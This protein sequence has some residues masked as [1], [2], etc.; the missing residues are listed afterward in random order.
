MQIGDIRVD[1]LIDGEVAVPPDMLYPNV[2]EAEW[3]PYQ[4]HLCCITG[5]QINTVGSFLIRHGDRVIL[6]DAGGGPQSIFPF[7]SGG[8]RSS[9]ALHGVAPTEITDVIYSH[10]HVD[11]YGWTSVNGKSFFPNATLRIDKR[12]WD[13]Y[14]NPDRPLDEWEVGVMNP[15]TDTVAKRFAPALSQIELFEGDAELL[16]GIIA[17]DAA[18]HTPGSTV[19][20]L[21]SNGESGLLIGDLV[22]TQP[23]LVRDDWFFPVNREPEQANEA[24]ERFRKR[25]YDEKL[26]FAAAHFPGMKWGRLTHRE[27][28]ELLY[29]QID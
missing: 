21:A 20:E 7:T 13:F 3:Q 24:K 17:H 10:L 5:M 1:A 19:I 16:P 4:G 9:L 29:E 14:S 11:H 12:E 26:P 8:L 22:H 15:E 23:E 27:G 2:G 25:I 6:H 28:S 18:G